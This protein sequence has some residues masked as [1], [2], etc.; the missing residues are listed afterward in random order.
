MKEQLSCEVAPLTPGFEPTYKSVAWSKH[1][2]TRIQGTQYNLKLE[3]DNVVLNFPVT[4]VYYGKNHETAL[5]KYNGKLI[6]NEQR[7]AYLEEKQKDWQ[8][9]YNGYKASLQASKGG[10][11]SPELDEKEQQYLNEYHLATTSNA[12]YRFVAV[13]NMGI[14]NIDRVLTQEYVLAETE[15]KDPKGEVLTMHRLFLFEKGINVSF[16]FFKMPT[17]NTVRFKYNPENT[18]TGIGITME[19][20]AFLIKPADIKQIK[21]EGINTINARE[22]FIPK[23][24]QE[25]REKLKGLV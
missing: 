23:S 16:E 25:L 4:P 5:K 15:F 6:E 18:Y 24:E 7:L 21:T 22:L 11:T 9:K 2:I 10:K 19:G 3:R 8:A 17:S 13:T 14:W 12:M 1:T 20:K